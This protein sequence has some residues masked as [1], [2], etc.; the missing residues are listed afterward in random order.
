MKLAL[1]CVRKLFL[2]TWVIKI[3]YKDVSCLHFEH[4]QTWESSVILETIVL[5]TIEKTENEAGNGPF[6]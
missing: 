3:F 2:G 6:Q 1:L 4:W 5:V